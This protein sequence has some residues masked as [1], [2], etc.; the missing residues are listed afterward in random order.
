MNIKNKTLLKLIYMKNYFTH[1]FLLLC[2]LLASISITGFSQDKTAKT[3]VSLAKAIYTAKGE[4]LLDL[5]QGAYETRL[6]NSIVRWDIGPAATADINFDYE[7][8]NL[9][10]AT[11]EFDPAIKVSMTAKDIC[12]GYNI[13]R[14]KYKAGGRLVRPSFEGID[15]DWSITSCAAPKKGPSTLNTDLY[16]HLEFNTDV[17]QLFL[18]NPFKSSSTVHR[19][20]SSQPG[21]FI[22]RVEFLP[23][24]ENGALRPPMTV[25]FREGANISLGDAGLITVDKNSGFQISRFDY[26]VTEGHGDGTLDN[27]KLNI[28]HGQINMGNTKL[29]L[30]PVVPASTTSLTIR[31]TKFNKDQKSIS[32]T[33]SNIDVT[34]GPNSQLQLAEGASK[35]SFF[36]LGNSKAS[37]TNLNFIITDGQS[38][39][40]TVSQARIELNIQ[41]GK[42][43]FTSQNYLE[44]G[45]STA[46]LDLEYSSWSNFS[47]SIKGVL[48]DV[49]LSLIDGRLQPDPHSV[50]D[51]KT[52]TIESKRL[53]VNSAANN[54][55]YGKFEKVDLR[56]DAGS[57]LNKPGKFS[58]TSREVYSGNQPQ[59]DVTSRFLAD[60]IAH[61][62]TITEKELF[63]EGRAKITLPYKNIMLY[64]SGSGSLASQTGYID[65]VFDFGPNMPL[66]GNFAIEAYKCDGSVSINKATKVDFYDGTVA[67][68]K[69]DIGGV[70]GVT[71]SFEE[72]SFILKT[73]SVFTLPQSFLLTTNPGSTFVSKTPE[74]SIE[75]REDRPYPVGTY[76]IHL[77]YSRFQNSNNSEFNIS[78]GEALFNLNNNAE[79]IVTGHDCTVSGTIN[80]G[81]GNNIVKTNIYIKDGTITSQA[82]IPTFIGVV[83]TKIPGDLTIP[84]YTTPFI[85]NYN[86]GADRVSKF[87]FFPVVL[88][89]R[90]VSDIPILN[91][92]FTIVER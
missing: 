75:F 74:Q 88:Q 90:T 22:T 50:L 32:L 39:Y 31:N 45:V 20:S 11:I 72:V 34:L 65:G 81:F 89:G 16:Q 17:S 79:G 91:A 8:G 53:T 57:N 36:Y 92:S 85:P 1:R 24:R 18:G 21:S 77:L 30:L 37:F 63:P 3:Y 5:Q 73:G 83:S 64:L 35:A 26:Y 28:Y 70:L 7:G 51:I 76:Q 71:G 54:P 52:G 60:D 2:V 12:V 41:S 29:N 49:T 48:S 23:G 25:L 67:S 33:G 56:L 66:T 68:K 15:P 61:P 27:F 86:T 46:T 47:Q 69:L 84:D 80:A 43:N 42:I 87:V 13:R 38:E 62:L 6:E 10:S 19:L 55:I 40:M 9:I 78:N 59:F 58:I 14:I 4:A 82:G 44:I